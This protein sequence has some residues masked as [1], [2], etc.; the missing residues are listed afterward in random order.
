MLTYQDLVMLDQVLILVTKLFC[1]VFVNILSLIFE[2]HLMVW[3]YVLLA[4]LEG[5]E[6]I[7]VVW[8]SLFSYLYRPSLFLENVIFLRISRWLHLC[9]ENFLRKHGFDTALCKRFVVQIG[10]SIDC[11]DC[12]VWRCSWCINE[13]HRFVALLVK[14]SLETDISISC[15]D[16]FYTTSLRF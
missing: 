4:R 5:C 16:S 11:R 9:L 14:N 6:G 12:Q 8:A 3:F 1:K 10:S 13:L 7:K 15:N 2:Q